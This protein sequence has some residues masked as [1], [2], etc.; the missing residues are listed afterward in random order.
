MSDS[1]RVDFA[2]VATAGSS[3]SLGAAR[4][5]ARCR[6]RLAGVKSIPAAA[7]ARPFV[8]R[9]RSAGHEWPL[10]AQVDGRPADGATRLGRCGRVDSATRRHARASAASKE[11]RLWQ[12][13][14]PKSNRTEPKGAASGRRFIRFINE[15]TGQAPLCERTKPAKRLARSRARLLPK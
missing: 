15:S 4:A 5:Q 7:S 9:T 6:Q 2:A 8:A 12:A 13:S 10:M 3:D 14:S 11:N 1:W